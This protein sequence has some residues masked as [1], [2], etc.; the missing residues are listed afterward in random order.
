MHV[1]IYVYVNILQGRSSA[2]IGALSWDL[3]GGTEK[4][5]EK[6]PMRLACVP[7]EIRSRHFPAQFHS[8]TATPFAQSAYASNTI[9]INAMLPSVSC[10]IGQ[11]ILR[12]LWILTARLCVHKTLRCYLI[13]IRW[14]HFMTSHP[15]F[16]ASILIPLFD[17]SVD[18]PRLLWFYDLIFPMH[19]SSPHACIIYV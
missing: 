2:Q 11:D 14:T 3:L 18:P 16:L 6:S 1:C 12:L 17:L 4:Y 13:L 15:I 8:D 7:P 10:I 19:F 9:T 5:H